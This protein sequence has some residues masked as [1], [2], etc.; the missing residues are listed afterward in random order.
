MT[1]ISFSAA[2]ANATSNPAIPNA[3]EVFAAGVL[4]LD[5]RRVGR[6][7]LMN[8][9]GAA[10]GIPAGG[11]HHGQARLFEGDDVR[12]RAL[13]AKMANEHEAK[14]IA[15]NLDRA[16]RYTHVNIFLALAIAAREHHQ[17]VTA[18]GSNL[19]NSFQEGGLDYL[20][21]EKKKLGLPHSV[22]RTWQPAVPIL[23]P[24]SMHEVH[25]ARIPA[26][27]QMLVYAAQIGASFNLNFKQ[28]LASQ[29]G[30]DA[31]PALARATRISL[32]VWQVYAFLAPGGEA[33][34]G[35]KTLG[36]QLGQNFGSRTA[37]G[38][39]AYSA[40]AASVKPDLDLI[41]RDRH[42]NQTEWVRSAKTRA[43]ETLF[44]E[45]LFR[46]ARELPN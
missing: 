39:V 40:S 25:P 13:L 23:N 45:R 2:E 18:T 43:A 21:D 3:K 30:A 17:A 46:R 31:D 42:L 38:Y 20:W 9:I 11:W 44:F 5:L 32:L 28:A 26:H 16:G 7:A 37:L 22:T 8:L 27:D 24:E 6:V 14:L 34:D 35:K 19:I 41:L 1:D 10:L 4:G 36:A 33:Y 12:L 15:N 29:F